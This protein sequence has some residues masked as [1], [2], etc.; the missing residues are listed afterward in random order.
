MLEGMTNTVSSLGYVGIFLLVLLAPT[1]P[2]IVLPFAGFMAA[3]GKLSLPYVI[4]AGVMGCTLSTLFWYAAARYLGESGLKALARRNRRWL[5]L[6]AQDFEKSKRWFD[7]HG[8]K[9][10]FF[11][12]LIPSVR[13]LIALP[14]GISGMKLLPFLLYIIAGATFW[15]GLLA[16]A[17]YVLSSRYELVVWY[18]APFTKIL[19][20]ALLVA[21]IVWLVR[22]KK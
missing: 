12:R 21:L 13:T 5:K 7:K 22:R 20:V 18:T 14:A 10:L 3:Q 6:S 17:G 19:V 16:Y 9:A 8:G 15:H 11:S 2:E 4:M 1:P